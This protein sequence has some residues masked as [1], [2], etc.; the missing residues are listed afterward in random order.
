[1]I[2]DK[3][4]NAVPKRSCVVKKLFQNIPPSP[5]MVSYPL[6]KCSK[7]RISSGKSIIVGNA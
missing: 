7:I 2:E 4:K 3:T 1:M 6:P 5:A